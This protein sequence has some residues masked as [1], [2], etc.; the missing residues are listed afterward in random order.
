MTTM[1]DSLIGASSACQIDWNFICWTKVEEQVRRLQVRIAKA[2]REGRHG[3]AKAL[4]WLLSHSFSAKLMAV[5]RVTQNKG[6]KTAGVDKVVWTTPKQKMQAAENIKRRG[7]QP[8]PLRRLY[9][10]KKN[11]KLRPL[12]IPTMADRVQ[13]ALHLLTLEPISETLADKNAYGF[14]PK[15]SCADAIEQCFIVLSRNCSAQWVL[16]GDIKSCFDKISHSWLLDNIPMDKIILEKWLKA[17][18]IEKAV[19]N[20]TDEGTPQGGIISPTLLVL[21][22][23]GLEQAVKAAVDPGDK[24]NII[25]YADDFIITGASREILESKVKPAVISFLKQRG[26]TLSEEKTHL[27][28]INDGFNFLGFNVRKYDGKLLIKPAKENVKIF[29][30]KLRNIIKNSGCA[31]TEEIIRQLNP[32][33]RGWSNYYRHVVSKETFSW[34]DRCI[35]RMLWQWAKRRHPKKDAH[36]RKHKYYRQSALQ[37]WIFFAKTRDKEGFTINLD[38]TKAVKVKIRRHLKI[39]GAAHPYDTEYDDYFDNRL[40]LKKGPRIPGTRDDRGLSTF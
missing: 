29:L 17:G 34:V 23:T 8:L 32:K 26:L 3:K 22:L 2:V 11:G 1:N 27:T 13:Q 12:S 14:R 16:E 28:H 10:P 24:V 38:L 9:I 5:R 20:P 6:S 40:R 7:Y 37:N 21:T 39:K 36:W 33:I 15:R 35:F 19:F 4:Q 31:T 25:V 30:D 18:Y